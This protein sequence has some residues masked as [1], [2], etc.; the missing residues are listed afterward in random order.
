MAT[1][2]ILNRAHL[3]QF[4]GSA[5]VAKAV[6]QLDLPDLQPV[7]DGQNALADGYVASQVSLPPSATAQAQVAPLVAELVLTACYVNNASEHQQARREAAFKTLRE[8]AS[9][10]LKLHV[11]PVVD[12]PATP[13]D[14][15]LVG[16]AAFGASKR[17]TKWDEPVGPSDW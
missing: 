10:T 3:E 5:L 1:P 12:N 17:L 7:I 9:G 2:Y 11:E 14:E 16:T 8:I 15:S 13:E 4:L 6:Q